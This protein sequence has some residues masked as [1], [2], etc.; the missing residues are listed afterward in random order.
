MAEMLQQ[1][2]PIRTVKVIFICKFYSPEGA[3]VCSLG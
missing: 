1:K 2:N 3:T